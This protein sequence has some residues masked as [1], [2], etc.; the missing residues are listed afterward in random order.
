METQTV[1]Q[2]D[3]ELRRLTIQNRL[4]RECEEPVLQRLLDGRSDV[5]VLDVGCNDGS[6]T[7]DRFNR[8]EIRRVIG[9]EYHGGLSERAR[10]RYGGEKFSFRACDVEAPDFGRW[11]TELLAAEGV[12]AFELIY[13]SFVLMHLKD[14]QALVRTLRPFLA[15]GGCLVIE[16]AADGVSG[17]EPDR[18]GLFREFLDMLRV[19][20]CAGNRTCG[21]RAA[22][23]LAA[24]GDREITDRTARICADGNDRQRKHDLFETFFS[25]LPADMA[26]LRQQEPENRQ[27]AACAAWLDEH[28]EELR[29]EALSKDSELTLGIRIVTGV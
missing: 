10:A 7:F 25:Y 13:V 11:L 12:A 22:G 1:F 15:P 21:D 4:L 29:R 18:D 28:Y 20:P 5:R 2:N 9:L 6:K 26:L 27:Y 19:D 17:L 23:W 14:P 16:E 3:R 8:P 24:G